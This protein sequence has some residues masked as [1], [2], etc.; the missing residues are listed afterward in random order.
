MARGTRQR[1]AET[2]NANRVA[3][4]L[5]RFNGNERVDVT[6]SNGN[7]TVA[8]SR[9]TITQTRAGQRQLRFSPNGTRGIRRGNIGSR[10]GNAKQPGGGSGSNS[11]VTSFR[12]AD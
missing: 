11:P 6:T 3:E 2:R 12:P 9:G 1:I 8:N 4:A 10:L 7:R 5:R